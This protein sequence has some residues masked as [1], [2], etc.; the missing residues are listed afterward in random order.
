MLTSLKEVLARAPAPLQF[1]AAYLD[2][3]AGLLRAI[4]PQ[5]IGA[6][7]SALAELRDSGG[8]LF[9]AGNGG[10][11]ATASHMANDFAIGTRTTGGRPL[12]AIALA[13]AVAT[14]T[15]LANDSGYDQVFV[16][17]LDVHFRPGDGLLAVSASGNSPNLLAAARWV[18]ARG[19]R[20]LALTGF[21]G[22]VLRELAD[23]VVHVPTASG[24]YGPVEDAHM[25]LDHLATTWLAHGGAVAVTS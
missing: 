13:D 22:G 21:D 3:V 12:R 7:L 23:V 19:G 5:Q 20:V 4:D 14:I 10:S 25:V 1:A 24:E 2:Y 17:Q 8:T 11:A 6:L 15:A 9:I 16:A 18:R